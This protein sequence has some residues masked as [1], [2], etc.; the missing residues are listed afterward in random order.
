MQ[1]DVM[2]VPERIIYTPSRHR[3]V[4]NVGLGIDAVKLMAA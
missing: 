4:Q 1:V 3:F 2:R